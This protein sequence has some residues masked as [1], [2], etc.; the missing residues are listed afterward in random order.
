MDENHLLKKPATPEDIA[1]KA[2]LLTPVFKQLIALNASA[3]GL[4]VIFMDRFVSDNRLL[5]VIATLS[6]L[7]FLG[8]LLASFLIFFKTSVMQKPAE[9]E[10]LFEDTTDLVIFWASFMGFTA[11]VLCL[12][13]IA[14]ANFVTALPVWVLGLVGLAMIIYAGCVIWKRMRGRVPKK[15]S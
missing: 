2:A 3:I 9:G 13:V 7:M 10:T 6:L 4:V 11:G 8:S 14:W 15:N 5:N 1:Q 12:M